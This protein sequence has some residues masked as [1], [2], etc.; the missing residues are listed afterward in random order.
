MLMMFSYGLAVMVSVGLMEGRQKGTF[1]LPN[2]Q[3][4]VGVCALGCLLM[5]QGCPRHT[6][7]LEPWCS[8]YIRLRLLYGIIY[9]VLVAVKIV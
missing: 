6:S 7:T 3:D 8:A 1:T 5:P 9:A 2:G 4:S